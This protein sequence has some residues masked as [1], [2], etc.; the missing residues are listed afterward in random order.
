MGIKKEEKEA[1]NIIEGI[2][3]TAADGLKGVDPTVLSKAVRG[4]ANGEKEAAKDLL[5]CLKDWQNPMVQMVQLKKS[6]FAELSTELNRQ[7]LKL[8]DAEKQYQT[9]AR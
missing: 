7:R 5:R 6:R 8:V 9:E 4:L 2:R 3:A 1:S